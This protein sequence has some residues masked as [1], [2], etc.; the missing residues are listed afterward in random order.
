MDD[1][2]WVWEPTRRR[3]GNDV[4]R[5]LC[6]LGAAAELLIAAGGDGSAPDGGGVTM[7]GLRTGLAIVG[8]WWAAVAAGEL[9]TAITT[10]RPWWHMILPL[11][12]IALV[13]VARIWWT[14]TP[15]VWVVQN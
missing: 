8:W 14:P 10:K 9:V 2:K 3:L 6:T 1:R 13:V 11:F 4:R 5:A 7:Y 15:L 12:V